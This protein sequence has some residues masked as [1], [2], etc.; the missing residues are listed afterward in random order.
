MAT[1]LI[2]QLDLIDLYEI[3]KRQEQDLRDL[4]LDVEALKRTFPGPERERFQDRKKEVLR[5][6]SHRA[7]SDKLDEHLRSIDATLAK[8]R[9]S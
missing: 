5:E 9:Q 4:S 6:E 1:K 3:V 7:K 8:L 2:T